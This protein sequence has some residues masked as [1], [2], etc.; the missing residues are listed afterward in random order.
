MRFE[1]EAEIGGNTFGNTLG[2]ERPDGFKEPWVLDESLTASGE[3]VYARMEVRV[4][5]PKT[6]DDVEA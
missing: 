1:I 5:I 2:L 3:P 6:T 4:T